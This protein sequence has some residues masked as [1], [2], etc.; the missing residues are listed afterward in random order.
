[1]TWV[2]RGVDGS[3][4]T[5]TGADT[6]VSVSVIRSRLKTWAQVSKPTSHNGRQTRDEGADTTMT[7]GG[8]MDYGTPTR[9]A[10]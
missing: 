7:G 2:Q 1:M 3:P 8:L 10:Q 6:R 5:W 4:E 9:P